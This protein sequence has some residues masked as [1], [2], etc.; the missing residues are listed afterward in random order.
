MKFQIKQGY[1]G[2][3]TYVRSKYTPVDAEEG[4][5]GVLKP[6]APSSIGCY[7]KLLQEFTIAELTAL[8][9]EGRVVITDHRFFV[10][11]NVY[12]P[13]DP[14]DERHAYK[15]RFYRAIQIRVEALIGAGREVIIVGDV[16]ACH[17]EVDHCDPKQSM[18]EHG[19]QNFQ[20]TP[21][22][23]WFHKF[24]HPLGPMVD[25]FRHLHPTT[26][27]AFTCWNT[28][29]NARYVNF[30]TRIDYILCTQGIVPWV[31]EA[32]VESQL[33][34]SDHCPVAVVLKDRDPKSQ[35][36]LLELMAPEGCKSDQKR[37]PP[38]LCSRYWQEFTGKQQKLSGFFM[39]KE[40][41]VGAGAG[42]VTSDTLDAAN[43]EMVEPMMGN[44]PLEEQREQF[45]AFV[46]EVVQPPKPEPASSQDSI[47]QADVK[48][49]S[50]NGTAVSGTDSD[51]AT[52][53]APLAQPVTAVLPLKSVPTE[54]K[55]GAAGLPSKRGKLSR[56]GAGRGKD[57]LQKKGQAPK[58]TAISS[59]FTKRTAS[60]AASNAD[61]CTVAAE[62]TAVAVQQDQLS[63]ESSQELPQPPPTATQVTIPSL[64]NPTMSPSSSPT[65]PPPSPAHP[66]RDATPVP[67]P[68]PSAQW[69]MLMQ[70]KEV[71]KCWHGE[72]AK[73]WTVNKTGPN[74][75]R[76]FY[77]C[78][79]PVGPGEGKG[80]KEVGEWRCDFFAWKNG[81]GKRDGGGNG[82]AGAG[83]GL[84]AGGEPAAKRRKLK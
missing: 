21:A 14:T 1:S 43:V 76:R 68:P 22:R 63:Q 12:F 4:F 16:N 80:K 79:R 23:Q 65:P 59:F 18:K 66:E 26:T 29:L 75:G 2:V 57:S 69:R 44:E 3:T 30:G 72:A 36:S 24:L 39:K 78:A 34:G 53:A 67:T 17:E 74:Q 9:S 82:G 61:L 73:E 5:T 47:D 50:S 64:S 70:P 32:T 41:S 31:E 10:L 33:F 20:D 38:R 60:D 15:M 55:Y 7:G 62:S 35:T 13:N 54:T 25:T 40:G 48:E 81:P 49:D 52:V 37:D 6:S 45:P 77:L 28:L 11:F 71:P 8:D 51:V 56:S 27:K 19:I 58:Q 46:L 42:S 84:G 83:G